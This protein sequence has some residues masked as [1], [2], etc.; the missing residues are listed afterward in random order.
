[1]EDDGVLVIDV[2]VR[3]GQGVRVRFENP[4][5]IVN[6]RLLAPTGE[7]EEMINEDG[8]VVQRE[9]CAED[10]G[11]ALRLMVLDQVRLQ[12]LRS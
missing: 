6:P 2:E 10:P 5:K 3:N 12:C 4:L 1:M 7:F 9:I 11:E 8:A